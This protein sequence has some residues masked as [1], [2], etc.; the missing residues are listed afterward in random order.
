MGRK[1]KKLTYAQKHGVGKGQYQ[2]HEVMKRDSPQPVHTKLGR[3]DGDDV[4]HYKGGGRGGM[5]RAYGGQNDP[6][7]SRRELVAKSRPYR[8]GKKEAAIRGHG[9]KRPRSQVTPKTRFAL[10]KSGWGSLNHWE[11]KNGEVNQK[12]REDCFGGNG[13]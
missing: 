6:S 1:E 4:R 3:E 12:G 11:N 10:E 7:S 2:W 13:T 5:F 8:E 9:S